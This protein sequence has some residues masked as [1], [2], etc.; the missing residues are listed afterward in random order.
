MIEGW[1][2]V[3]NE[4]NFAYI[5]LDDDSE[6]EDQGKERPALEDRAP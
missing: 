2:Q 6:D 1:K 3:P 5:N 4:V